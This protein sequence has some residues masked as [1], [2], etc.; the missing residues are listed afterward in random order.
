MSVQA[1]LDMKSLTADYLFAN[2]AK[3]LYNKF[4]KNMSVSGL[5]YVFP[6]EKLVQEYQQRNSGIERTVE[7]QVVAYAIIVS[8]T[9]LPLKVADLWLCSLDLS[10]L[11]WGS[12]IRSIYLRNVRS[13][14]RMT[15]EVAHVPDVKIAAQSSDFSP[16]IRTFEVPPKTTMRRL[17]DGKVEV[18]AVRQGG[19]HRF[20][21][22]GTIC[23]QHFGTLKPGDPAVRSPE[24]RSTNYC[25]TQQERPGSV[26][27]SDEGDT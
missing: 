17:Y 10:C 11:P 14:N 9:F 27:L 5:I 3:Y 1:N 8:F 19:C 12:S 20:P 2:T 6:P 26:T 24:F 21:D 25:G 18:N 13:N 23:I 22:D 16:A 15:I 4:R 7:D